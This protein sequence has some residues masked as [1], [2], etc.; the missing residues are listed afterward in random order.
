MKVLILDIDE[1][2]I[3]CID[4]RDSPEMKGEHQLKVRVKNN[5]KI[6]DKSFS[7]ININ[8]NLRPGL[9]E[10]LKELSKAY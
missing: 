6:S 4:D 10:C 8:V 1:T 5:N 3:H 7:E 9:H 2:M